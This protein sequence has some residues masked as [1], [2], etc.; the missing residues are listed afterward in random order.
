M[1]VNPASQRSM[2]IDTPIRCFEDDVEK[3]NGEGKILTMLN[4][5]DPTLIFQTLPKLQEE[6]VKAAKEK[7]FLTHLLKAF[8]F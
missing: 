4:Q 5:G 8:L 3:L 7:K 1:Q 2:G 6:L